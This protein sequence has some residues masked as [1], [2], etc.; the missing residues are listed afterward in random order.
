[1]SEYMRNIVLSALYEDKD[2]FLD[3]FKKEL[4]NRIRTKFDSL[5]GKSDVLNFSDVQ[6]NSVTEEDLSY[7]IIPFIK[8]CIDSG[9]PVYIDLLD[10]STV[11]LSPSQAKDLI[12][13]HDNLNLDNQN[14][15]R[16]SLMESKDSYNHF[17][18]F[19]RVKHQ[20]G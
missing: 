17:V 3:N 1:M 14:K 8:E 20:G 11:S 19:S 9:S 6:N 7:K 10:K 16:T 18:E 2:S 5:K 12:Y 15:F 4:S 13:I